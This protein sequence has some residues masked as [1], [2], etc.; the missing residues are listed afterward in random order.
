MHA[1]GAIAGSLAGVGSPEGAQLPQLSE[2]QAALPQP[3]PPSLGFG[4]TPRARIC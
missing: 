2:E 3:K 4:N 1:L